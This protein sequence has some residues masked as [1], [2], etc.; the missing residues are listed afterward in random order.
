[1]ERETY[2]SLVETIYDA[3]LNPDLWNSAVSGIRTAFNSEAAGFFIETKDNQLIEDHIVGIDAD[4]MDVYGAHY[5]EKNPWFTVPGL[6]KP[7]RVL[8]DYS[9][10]AIYKDR[11]AFSSTDFYQGWCKKLDFRHLMG[12][13]LRDMDGTML[14]FTFFRSY[15]SGHY[16][17]TE[18]LEYS[19]LCRHLMR[20]VEVN[21]RLDNSD[22]KAASTETILDTLKIAV[23]GLGVSGRMEYMN[24][25]ARNLIYSKNGL[26]DHRS[27]LKAVS[28]SCNRAL[29][30]GIDSAYV[31]EISS[32]ITINRVQNSPLT[33]TILPTNGKRGFLGMTS[34]YVTLLITDPDDRDIGNTQYLESK[35]HLA[36]MEAKFACNLLKGSSVNQTAELLEMT[37]ETA[38]WYSKQVMRKLDVNSQSA[39]IIKLMRDISFIDQP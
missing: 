19:S 32:S 29:L 24:S 10:E 21:T 20:A 13:N 3:A 30:H 39:L 18:I 33:I 37:K 15:H 5:A 31:H 2:N 27:R 28:E 26:F 34:R 14:N 1:M 35:W 17:D 16:R 6:M 9:L 38:R 11:K 12:G 22:L 4:V 23:V 36:P 8:T 7:G 25:S